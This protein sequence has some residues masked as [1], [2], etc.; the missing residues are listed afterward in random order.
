MTRIRVL[1]VDD[2]PDWHAG[3]RDFFRH[4]PDIELA[5]CVATVAE[6]WPVLES[7]PLD[8]VLL[9][10]LLGDGGPSGVDAAADLHLAFPHV[11]V[12]MFSSLDS[13][14]DTFNE[15]FLNGAYDYIYKYELDQLPGVITAA[16]RDEQ[17]KY[18]E[19]LRAL[20]VERKRQLL[21][22][23]DRDLLALLAAGHSQQEIAAL[24][25]LTEEAIKKRVARLRKKFGW[26]RSTRELAERCRMWGLLEG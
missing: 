11:R 19:R 10:V 14:D 22:D 15:A 9:D 8:I 20:L 23:A 21:H 6:A 26:E 7:T 17:S 18:G 5:A 4:Y 2:D 3:L 25:H 24:E 12:I 13:D 1:Y 16:A